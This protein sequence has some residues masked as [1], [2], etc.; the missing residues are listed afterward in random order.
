MPETGIAQ[1]A[2]L[3]G[4]QPREASH[5]GNAA[6][7]Y[8]VQYGPRCTLRGCH[9][10]TC[11]GTGTAVTGAPPEL[12]AELVLVV[13]RAAPR[14]DVPVVYH[15]GVGAPNSAVPA[16]FQT[17]AGWWLVVWLALVGAWVVPQTVVPVVLPSG[18]GAHTTG[19]S[20]YT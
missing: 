6:Q 13:A 17:G 18:V 7:V 2:T 1:T 14:A 11:W 4:A 19:V 9:A 10:Q 5:R 12:V 16:G 15:T 8:D 3:P 20:G